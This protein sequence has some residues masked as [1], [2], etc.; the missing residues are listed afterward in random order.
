MISYRPVI[1]SDAEQVA[2]IYNNGWNFAFREKGLM[3]AEF[4][5]RA[6][7]GRLAGLQ[8]RIPESGSGI[9]NETGTRLVV[10]VAT[11]SGVDQVIGACTVGPTRE[12]TEVPGFPLELQSLYID[13]NF[14]GRGIGN[15]LVKAGIQLIGWSE[16][17]GKMFVRVFEK[18]ERAIAFYTRKLGGKLY[19]LES[20]AK[21]GGLEQRVAVIVWDNV[22]C[23]L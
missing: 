7:E 21:F 19:R 11:E 4:I 1:P 2:Q 15:G 9:M 5:D 6:N 8:A 20:S 10:A 17:S 12:P 22:T 18:N 23:V 14:H 3:T 16:S 13:S